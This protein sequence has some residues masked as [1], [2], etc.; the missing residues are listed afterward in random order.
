MLQTKP[1]KSILNKHK[2]RDSWFLDDYSVNPYEGC[3]CNCLYCYIRGSKYGIHMEQKL[4]L[5]TNAV[6]L[7]D[8]QLTLRAKKNQYGVIV[9]SSAT[10]PYLQFESETQITRQ[11]LQVIAKHKFPLHLITRSNGVL[12]DLDLIEQI[13]RESIL[14]LELNGRVQKAAF[15][16]FSFSTLDDSIASIFEP[17]ATAPSI[18]LETLT[19]VVRSGALTGV[20]LMPLLPFISDTA[21]NLEF[22]YAAFKAAGAH[23]LFAAGLTLFGTD[24]SNSKPMVL[25]AIAKHFPHLSEKYEKW[26]GQSDYLPP[27]YQQA[28]RKKAAELALKY[29]LRESII[30][31]P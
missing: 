21:E 12:R 27:A 30:H 4:S 15:V 14:P 29:E 16:T 10:E 18:R 7:L 31:I 24:P 25:R 26:F 20:S 9:L 28:F 17:G 3:S 5:K 22:M 1:V 19:E 6:E 2:K 8:K 23:Y 13:G 11:L